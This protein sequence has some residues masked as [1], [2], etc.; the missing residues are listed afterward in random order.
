MRYT[1]RVKHVKWLRD[2][3]DN[4]MFFGSLGVFAVSLACYLFSVPVRALIERIVTALMG[5]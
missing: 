4:L 1:C 5:G 3:P 2:L